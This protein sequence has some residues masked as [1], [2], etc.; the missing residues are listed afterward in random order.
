MDTF[1]QDSEFQPMKINGMPILLKGTNRHDTDP[2]YGKYVPEATVRQDIET[3]KR[4]N[5]NAVRTSHYSNDEYLYYLCDK[6][7]LYVMAETN[8]ESHALMNKGDSQKHFK[9]M[10]MDRT[11]TAYNRLK[12]R[13]SV[14]MWSTGNENYYNSNK[15]YADGMFY[16]LIQ[17]FKEKDPPGRSTA[18]VPVIKTVWIWTAICI[19]R[20]ER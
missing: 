2:V 7:G 4:F 1:I 3:M 12:D 15:N 18:R 5:L 9:K 17:Y 6:Y 14:V 11:V 16:D 13:T 10:V 19:P 20:W 8:V